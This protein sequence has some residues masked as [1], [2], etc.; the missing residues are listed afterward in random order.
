MGRARGK[1]LGACV[2]VDRA[3]GHDEWE[4]EMKSVNRRK[5]AYLFV[6]QSLLLLAFVAFTAAVTLSVILQ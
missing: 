5:E 2:A 1:L 6:S 3:T 4:A